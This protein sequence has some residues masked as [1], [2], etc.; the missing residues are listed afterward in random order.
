[1]VILIFI[2]LSTVVVAQIVLT[3]GRKEITHTLQSAGKSFN[4][5]IQ[6]RQSLLQNKGRSL[7]EVPYLK[8]TMTIDS[9]DQETADYLSQSL[10][11]IS[12]SD[13]LLLL[14]QRGRLLAHGGE[15]SSPQDDLSGSP[16]VGDA[17]EGGELTGVWRYEDKI[18]LATISTLR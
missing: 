9:L 8:A 16:M 10:H 18:Y 17:L 3:F 15:P 7:A 13:L 6:T 1:M 14:D 2:I 5:Y 12:D 11:E 4:R